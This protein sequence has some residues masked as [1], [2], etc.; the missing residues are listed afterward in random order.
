MT[1]RDQIIQQALMLPLED[2]KYVADLLEGS[3]PVDEFPSRNLAEAW[4][5]EIDRRIAEYDRGET[6][7]ADFE[8]AINAIRDTLEFHRA[9]KVAQ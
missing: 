5:Q 6:K 7:A 2:R 8:T 4:T 9:G 3:L 1:L